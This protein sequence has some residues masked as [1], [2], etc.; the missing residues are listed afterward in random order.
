M[1]HDEPTLE[2]W[3]EFR[4]IEEIIEPMVR[5]WDK[6]TAAGNDCVYFPVSECNLVETIDAGPKPLLNSLRGYEN[7]LFALG[8]LAVVANASDIATTG[9]QPLSMAN[10]ID[11]PSNLSVYAFKQLMSGYI[12]AC[13][14]FGFRNGGGNIRQ[15]HELAMHV[16]ATGISFNPYRI[17]RD[18]ATNGNIIYVI[19][20]AG[21]FMSNYL[22]AESILLHNSV[23]PK[24]I[25]NILRFPRPQL[26]AMKILVE[27]GL[28]VAASD[29]SDGLLGALDNIA[30]KSC[31]SFNLALSQEMLIPEIQQAA[32]LR[33]LNPWNIFFAFGD[34]S[35]AIVIRSEDKEALEQAC[36]ENDINYTQLGVIIECKEN[37]GKKSITIDDGY[38]KELAIL[39]SENFTKMGFNAKL[40]NHLDYILK[41]PLFL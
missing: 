25:E 28:V 3:G 2:D 5:M 11:V 9:A 10:S 35:V 23:L 31:C 13:S 40:S 29:S 33:N 17:G 15:R 14:E 39:R 20:P 41:T 1:N 36:R 32:K 18:G 7:D 21:R 22:I 19:G 38:V 27:C 26:K 24:D 6:Q 30:I 37:R 12:Q 16:C 4:L 34:W 8:W